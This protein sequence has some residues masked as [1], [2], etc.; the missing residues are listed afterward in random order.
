MVPI[1]EKLLCNNNVVIDRV[2]DC[3]KIKNYRDSITGE[4][5]WFRNVIE[6][7]ISGTE[8]DIVIEN[9]CD[10]F[11][12]KIRVERLTNEFSINIKKELIF[13]LI[14]NEI[15][16]IKFGE[17]IKFINKKFKTFI[18]SYSEWILLNG[19]ESEKCKSI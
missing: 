16:N 5:Y 6:C 15:N 4:M 19:M 9:V 7:I 13:I 12:G 14:T 3:K 17:E 11:G 10:D 8:T 1:I 2:I 18:L